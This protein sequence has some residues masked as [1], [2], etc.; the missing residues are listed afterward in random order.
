MLGGIR[1]R[2]SAADF[3]RGS[4]RNATLRRGREQEVDE[5]GVRR[6]TLIYAAIVGEEFETSTGLLQPFTRNRAISFEVL[7]ARAQS[8]WQTRRMRLTEVAY[9]A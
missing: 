4:S 9:S 5:A 8:I 7:V 1:A 3:G 2:I 6:G